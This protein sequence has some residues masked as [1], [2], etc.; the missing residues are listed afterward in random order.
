MACNGILSHKVAFIWKNLPW[1]SITDP[2]PLQR[3]KGINP[4]TAWKNLKRTCHKE[5]KNG[6]DLSH[7]STW[8]CFIISFRTSFLYYLLYLCEWLCSNSEI[9]FSLLNTPK[10]PCIYLIHGSSYLR[11][12]FKDPISSVFDRLQAQMILLSSPLRAAMTTEIIIYWFKCCPTI[13][14]KKWLNI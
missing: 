9:Y 4:I 10:P 13:V 5:K 6:F 14:T 8:N 2:V 11:L 1:N 3:Q 7:L 12:W